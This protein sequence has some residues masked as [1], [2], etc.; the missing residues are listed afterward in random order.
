MQRLRLLWVTPDVPRRGV[1]AARGYWWALLARLAPR[2]DVTL[3]ALA[4]AADTA[5]DD[6]PAGLAGVRLVPRRPFSPD[7]PYA[8]LPQAVAGRYADPALRDAIATAL[9]SQQYDLAQYE[10][11]ET[12]HLAPDTRTPAVLAVHQI[13]FAAQGPR[14]RAEGRGLRSGAVLLH[15]Y[16]RELDFELR[17]TALADHVLTVTAEDAAR[18]RRFLPDL[19]VSVSP[20]GVDTRDFHPMPPRDDCRSDVLFV[21][22]FIHP[23]N[24]DAV[25]FLATEVLPRL[26]RGVR[27][28]V[29]GHGAEAAVAA[30]GA[31]GIT[32]IG[33]V[34][35]L[36]P[37]LASATAV[38]APVR[39]GTGMRGKVLEAL[40]MGRPVVTTTLGAEGLGAVAGRHLLVADHAADFGA[41]VRRVLGDAELRTRLGQEGRALVETRFDWDG[42]ADALEDTWRRVLRA[43]RAP[44]RPPP[45]RFAIPARPRLR[46]R[47]AIAAGAIRLLWRGA[48]W[49]ARRLAGGA[50]AV[51]A[52]HAVPLPG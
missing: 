14:W 25:R 44:D 15:R 35:D 19:P 5:T 3:L 16:L 49:H 20:V 37:W 30:L 32:A 24:T 18:L 22:N 27:V 33:A 46:G 48:A 36:R 40:A 6:L 29:V 9:A 41:A 38:V 17:A 1:S 11:V 23:P 39:F 2:H 26:D 42:I 43:R 8:L 51:R 47:P 28:C 10:F 50:G 34:D 12:A 31:T 21:G 52:G 4:D 45:P 7:D 13:G